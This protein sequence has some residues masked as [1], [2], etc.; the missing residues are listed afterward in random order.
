MQID[1]KP[2]KDWKTILIDTSI[3][4][5]L[6][7]AQYEIEDA[8]TVFINKLIKY[9]SNSKSSD[10]S[11]RIF[12]I[13]TITL[14]E[15]LTKEQDEKKVARI[16]SVLDSTNVQFRS[17]DTPTAIAF[18]LALADKLHKSVL[19]AKAAEL[20]WKTGDYMSAREWIIKDYMIAMTGAVKKVDVIL[21]AD[22]N[23]FYPLCADIDSCNCV[24]TYPELFHQTDAFILEYDYKNVDNFIKK[25]PF[26]TLN[27]I[28]DEKPKLGKQAQ[29]FI[30]P[31]DE[32]P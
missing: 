16:L 22:K 19:N 7:R 11:E 6:F 8:V 14:S 18:N 17:F 21:T 3:I 15:L 1:N 9:L 27:Q 29:M 12:Y 4:C 20:G 30:V 31:T 28:E 5:A 2:I 24:I 23:T 10:N 13:S 32:K 26:K 25:A